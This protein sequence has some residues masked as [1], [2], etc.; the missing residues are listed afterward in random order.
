MRKREDR[1]EQERKKEGI[2]FA[3]CI[4]KRPA[5]KRGDVKRRQNILSASESNGHPIDGKRKG[6][7]VK[8]A[9]KKK[10]GPSLV[11]GERIT[12]FQG[13][14]RPMGW[15][16]LKKKSKYTEP[17]PGRSPGRRK[18]IRNAYVSRRGLS[19]CEGRA[20]FPQPLYLR[21]N[22]CKKTLQEKVRNTEPAAEKSK[23]RKF[24]PGEGA[25]P[26]S[27]CS[28]EGHW[29]DVFITT[30]KK[31]F[32]LFDGQ[33]I[34]QWERK[35]WEESTEEER[36]KTLLIDKTFVHIP[37]SLLKR[38]K[39]GFFEATSRSKPKVCSH[40]H[41][42][43][44]KSNAAFRGAKESR[45]ESRPLPERIQQR[46]K[47]RISGDWIADFSKE[48]KQKMSSMNHFNRRM[49]KN[50]RRAGRSRA[51]ILERHVFTSDRKEKDSGKGHYKTKRILNNS[52]G[53]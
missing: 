32:L 36:I 8:I 12:A 22:K 17:Q 44:G 15:K 27:A 33:G 40:R 7:D 13:K 4:R 20:P 43:G 31:L 35:A 49:G 24:F 53:Y 29:R 11:F 28:T 23:K 38:R 39:L 50:N 30:A 48:G 47:K 37:S 26:G 6:N 16:P 51:F 1:P 46:Q 41:G 52:S 25:L 5:Y 42:S 21:T 10:E 2:V 19:Q 18:G 14:G 45:W 9:K 34:G 3:V